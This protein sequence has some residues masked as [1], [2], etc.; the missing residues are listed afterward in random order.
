M[1]RTLFTG[2]N[3][4]DETVSTGKLCQWGNCVNEETLSTGKLC[5]RGNS[6]NEETRST[7]KLGQLGN[8]VNWETRSTGKLGQLGNSV[9]W[10]TRSTGKLGQLGNSVNW[11]TLSMRK[12]C[13]L[14]NSVNEETL[15]T[16]KLCQLAKT[17]NLETWTYNGMRILLLGHSITWTF[18][19]LH[20]P[21]L[22]RGLIGLIAIWS[23]RHMV[24]GIYLWTFDGMDN[25]VHRFWPWI[26]DCMDMWSR[27]YGS[28][29]V[30]LQ[31]KKRYFMHF[32]SMDQG[33]RYKFLSYLR[34]TWWRKWS[35]G[36][37]KVNEILCK[38]NAA[39]WKSIR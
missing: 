35:L 4:N 39:N 8:S 31:N 10:E 29:F 37:G 7:R 2:E 23:W 1:W 19:C 13:L 24:V 17:A 9:N 22:Y 3:V 14:G 25:W 15:S 32:L 27:I 26:F 38:K 21:L 28:L 6:V 5:Q 34:V 18:R 12:L 16:W 33:K 11:E 36:K 20:G 30:S